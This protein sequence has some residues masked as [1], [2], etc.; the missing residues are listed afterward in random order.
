VLQNSLIVANTF[1]TLNYALHLYG[2]ESSTAV[3]ESRPTVT[4]AFTLL[5]TNC[6]TGCSLLI[7][8]RA[9]SRKP[10]SLSM[11]AKQMCGQKLV[12]TGRRKTE[13]E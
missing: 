6:L 9:E 7:Q 4:A 11:L 8:M 12:K 2:D 3:G 13:K 5:L 10:Y 1:S